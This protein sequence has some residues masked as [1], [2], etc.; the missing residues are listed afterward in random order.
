MELTVHEGRGRLI[1]NHE[2][3]TASVTSAL[4]VQRRSTCFMMEEGCRQGLSE[5]VMLNFGAE[6]WGRG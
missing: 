3:L 2:K 1:D 5:E 6:K 4:K